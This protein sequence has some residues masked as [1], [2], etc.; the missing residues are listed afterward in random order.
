MFSKE[1]TQPSL[2]TKSYKQKYMNT[3]RVLLAFK[4]PCDALPFVCLTII[5]RYKRRFL[6]CQKIPLI[7][8]FFH[9]SMIS[10][11]QS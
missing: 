5:I 11:Y 3:R 1:L 10:N 4:F 6:I 2:M 7:S 8:L 9:N